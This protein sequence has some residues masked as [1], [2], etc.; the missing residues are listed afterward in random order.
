MTIP[1]FAERQKQWSSPPV[2]DI[3]YIPAVDLLGMDDA[4][5]AATIRAMWENRY[6][7]WR[8]YRSRW[9]EVLKLLGETTGKRV[10]DYGC[11][12]GLEAAIY[13]AEGNDVW[14]ADISEANLKVAKRTM[15]LYGCREAGSMWIR[16][17]N[18][19][20]EFP[21]PFDVIHCCGVLHHIPNARQ[22]VEAMHG[23]LEPG[24][25]LRLMVYSDFAWRLATGTQPPENVLEDPNFERYWQRWDAVGGYADWYS[26]RK[27][28]ERFGDLFKVT[29]AT[30]LTSDRAYL[31]AVLVKR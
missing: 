6:T 8:N 13:A 9:V 25:E 11:G 17:D 21:D 31:G 29:N 15:A 19:S 3:G 4:T 7:G 24:G 10:L 27:L 30:Y 23:W 28:R 16:N 20:M 26:E 1:S 12:V 18:A 14:I 22:A 2:D 5:F